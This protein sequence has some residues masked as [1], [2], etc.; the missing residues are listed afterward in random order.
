MRVMLDTNVLLWWLTGSDRLTPQ[1]EILVQE[2]RNTVM[3]SSISAA[4]IGI[5][6]S[7]GKLPPLPEPL[8]EA[9]DATGFEELPFT[10]AHAEIMATLPWHHKDP[11][12]RMLIAQAFA[13]G[14]PI[15]TADR[16]FAQ[17]GIQVL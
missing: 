5:K 7:I 9:M 12:D 6:T 8:A 2:P 15:L 10:I 13:E 11:F 3:V 16:I 4:E 1:W 17:Y 14:C